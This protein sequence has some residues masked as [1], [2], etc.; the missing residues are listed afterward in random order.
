[1]LNND[2][3]DSSECKKTTK[4]QL[5]FL[6]KHLVQAVA[7]EVTEQPTTVTVAEKVRNVVLPALLVSGLGVLAIRYPHFF[8]DVNLTHASGGFAGFVLTAL[9]VLF[10]K[11]GWNQVGGTLAIGLS[12]FAIARCLLPISRNFLSIN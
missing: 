1:M 4:P 10:L 8:D 9:F 6:K 3:P 2:P 12:L 5:N 11:F 7:Q